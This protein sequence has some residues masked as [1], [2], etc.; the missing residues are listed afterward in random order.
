M[1][2]ECG[3]GAAAAIT[4][5]M[6]G[7]R[8]CRA[9][10]RRGHA[11]CIFVLY[12]GGREGGRRGGRGTEGGCGT[13]GCS[14]MEVG[15]RIRSDGVGGG[16]W[17]GCSCRRALERERGRIRGPGKAKEGGNDGKSASNVRS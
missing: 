13:G 16:R 8:R 14:E 17:A 4:A 1:V 11:L 15:A 7:G 6:P 3:E 5:A 2:L 10:P 9:A 12:C